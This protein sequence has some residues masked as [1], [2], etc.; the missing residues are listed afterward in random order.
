MSDIQFGLVDV[1][2]WCVRDEEAAAG[3]EK[4]WLTDP[5]G[6][7][8]LFKP[9]T[10]HKRE[11]FVRGEDWSEKYP[12]RWARY[13]ACLAPGSSLPFA[14]GGAGNRGRRGHS[15]VNIERALKGFGPP[16][17]AVATRP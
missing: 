1:S 15:L 5:V 13:L 9:V 6:R 2:S 16:R 4:E 10:E 12:P 11:G 3:D 7:D 14:T 8:W 17:G